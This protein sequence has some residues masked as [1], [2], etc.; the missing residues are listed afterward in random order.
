[1]TFPDVDTEFIFYPESVSQWLEGT[2]GDIEEWSRIGEV[3]DAIFSARASI[4]LEFEAEPFIDLGYTSD[5]CSTATIDAFNVFENQLVDGIL[6]G[7]KLDNQVY[8]L[9]NVID[10]LS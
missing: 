1:M 9:N 3:M 6:D 5:G 7:F 8:F 10:W 4:G 2:N